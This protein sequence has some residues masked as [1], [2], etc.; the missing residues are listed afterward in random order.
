MKKLS[1]FLIA[2]AMI[3][4]SCKPEIEKP[5][6]VTKSVGE[7]TQTSAKVVGQVAADGGAEVT[8]RGV[9][10]STDGT[11]T[12]LDYRVKDVDGG[13]GSYDILF[14]DLVP[15]TQYY[16]RAYA[17]N[18]AGTGY[19][20]EKTFKTL[21]DEPETPVD[22]EEPGDEPEEPG[23][24]PEE[25]GDE[26]EEPGDEPEEPEDP[27]QP[28]DPE[29][30]VDPEQPEDPETPVDPEEPGDDPE[31]PGD[32]PEEPGDDPE[33][34]GDEPETPEQPEEVA[35]EV[36]TAEVTDITVNS[37]K[38]GGEVINGG[39]AVVVARGVCWNT[40]GQPTVSDTYAMNG[41]NVGSFTSQISNLVPNTQYYVRAYATNA[42]GVTGYGEEVSFTT[43]EK[44]LPTVT[45][46]IEVT[47]ITV[48]K[49]IC[50][51][52]VTFNGNVTV[53]ARGICWSTT[54][55]PTIEDNKTTNGSGV[56]SYTS[57]MTNL[58]HNT[59]YYVRAYA[60]NEVGTAYG[61]EVSFTTLEK[62]LPT[63]TTAIEVT[64]ITVSKAICG[65]E[66]TFNGNVTVT[67]RGI[68][69]G[70]S[71]NPTIE[72]NKTTNGSGVGSYTSNMTN[73]EHNTTYYVRAY[74]T[75]EVGTAYG[76]EVSFMTIEKLLPTVTT[77]IEVTDITLT[78]AV[79][80]GEVTFDGNVAVTAKGI[81]WSTTQ[82]PTIEDNKTTN[83][84]G[85]GSYTSNMTNLEHNTTYYVR[86]YAT[87]EVG[88]AYG[89]EKSFTT[90]PIEGTTNDHSWVDL[91]LPS[92]KKWATC[93]VGAT[94]PE[95]YGDYFAWGETS[96]KAEYTEENSTIYGKIM[97]DISGNAQYD[98]AR[99]NWGGNWRMPTYDELNELRNNCTW[100]WT[101]QNGVKGY[102]V[103][104]PSGNSIFLPAAGRRNGSSLNSA[105][106]C[107]Y[108]WSSTPFVDYY[109]VYRLYFYSSDH[110]MSSCSRYYGHSVRPILE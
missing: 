106:S 61:E 48:S 72:D 96:T 28:E 57:N 9:C 73:L 32:E 67:A 11:P 41:T 108:Y 105:G 109:G 40:S 42:K 21:D 82:N 90:L 23:D 75:N 110:G 2:L 77:A 93:N 22:P 86:A 71:Q 59:T 63:V 100:T 3:L 25:P 47:D 89:E 26:P 46:A 54:Q 76:E 99:A 36:T 24:D 37:A 45:T 97:N 30:P 51:G 33:N 74:A 35:P 4:V 69:W 85:V 68:C 53:T 50:G 95:E 80:G 43:L 66:V 13:L 7:V 6:V 16:V 34:P 91:G 65:G 19:G 5:T 20:D 8:E 14:T 15:N 38:C 12:I 98:A 17:T 52:E 1:L 56:G 103:E 18:E 58:E 107:G 60:T 104:G 88:T 64:D 31:E 29:T 87:N 102:N 81:C 49:A 78:S 94:S 84:S 27:E 39:D 55:N 10:W 44:L 79:C 83:G 62:L 101:T 70:T 92:G